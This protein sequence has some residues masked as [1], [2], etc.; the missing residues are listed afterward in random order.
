MTRSIFALWLALVS[1]ILAM[2][3]DWAVEVNMV[4]ETWLPAEPITAVFKYT[5]TS[6]EN[7]VFE[8]GSIFFDD[9]DAPCV[10]RSLGV[11]DTPPGTNPS[12]PSYTQESFGSP[13]GTVRTH[14]IEVTRVCNLEMKDLESLIGT[15]TIC[16][17]YP[18]TEHRVCAE[19]EI[20]QPTGSNADA[21]K[22]FPSDLRDV[23]TDASRVPDSLVADYP[24]SIYA[25]YV[26]AR[27]LSPLPGVGNDPVDKVS[28]LTDPGFFSRFPTTRNRSKN[29]KSEVRLPMEEQVLLAAELRRDFLE[30]HPDFLLRT[31]LEKQLGDLELV[32]G[33]YDRAYE[34]WTWVVSHATENVAWAEG[35]VEAIEMQELVEPRA[36]TDQ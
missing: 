28:Q 22:L 5:N 35:M 19:F 1:S 31:D 11:V 13:P 30:I 17:Q 29:A 7:A 24:T 15:H 25:G 23:V 16:H 9:R 18:E 20:I 6:A 4:Q 33:N 34:A 12:D 32:L 21:V 2:A 8:T 14:E 10:D 36:E 3:G 27:Q 26:F